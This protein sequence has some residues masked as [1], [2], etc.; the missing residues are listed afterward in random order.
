MF[1]SNLSEHQKPAFLSLA[2]SLIS[3]D[4]VLSKDETAMM[5]Q[6]RQEMGLPVNVPMPA[7]TESVYA[8]QDAPPSVKKQ[9]VFELV[10]LACADNDYADEERGLLS[11]LC[12]AWGLDAAFLD[13]CGP[14]VREL[15]AVYERIA[16][17]VS[18]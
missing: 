1:L 7:E 3:A 4:G 18:E 14:C 6:Y 9:I 16:K 13:D 12:G 2:Q 10:A 17:L 11:K 5:E 8:F 15:T